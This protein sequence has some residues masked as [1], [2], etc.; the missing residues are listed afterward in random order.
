[1]SRNEII[2]FV[3]FLTILNLQVQGAW[4]GPPT[5]QVTREP[6]VR[7][8]STQTEDEL[9][10]SVTHA[11]WTWRVQMAN[12]LEKQ[13]ILNTRE[14][15]RH[16]RGFVKWKMNRRAD[17]FSTH[18]SSWMLVIESAKRFPPSNREYARQ[19]SHGFILYMKGKNSDR[20]P[21]DRIQRHMAVSIADEL[22]PWVGRSRGR[23]SE[24]DGARLL[25]KLQ[26][27]P[28]TNEE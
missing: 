26:E 20:S 1:M 21:F 8:L 28:G 12:R 18:A 10:D 5:G 23:L 7:P 15:E 13:G 2:Q 14:A 22:E 16:R 4:A 11:S 3:F 6:V 17:E 24:S 19:L 25:L 9:F 27:S